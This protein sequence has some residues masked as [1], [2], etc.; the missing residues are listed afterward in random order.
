MYNLQ[1]IR[2]SLTNNANKS[3]CHN[4]EKVLTAKESPFS[5]IRNST[6]ITIYVYS[7][8]AGRDDEESKKLSGCL[9]TNFMDYNNIDRIVGY[10]FY[11]LRPLLTQGKHNGL[12][13]LER[14]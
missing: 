13:D 2:D 8:L 14:L 3:H 5:H 11:I 12:S 10:V 6:S 1:D 7:N 9:M 4:S